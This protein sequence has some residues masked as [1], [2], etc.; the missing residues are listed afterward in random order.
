[1]WLS[2]TIG[3]LTGR[4]KK[5]RAAAAAISAP[6]AWRFLHDPDLTTSLEVLRDLARP[7]FGGSRPVA[8]AL[9]RLVVEVESPRDEDVDIGRVTALTASKGRYIGNLRRLLPTISDPGPRVAAL[10]LD[11]QYAMVHSDV[12]RESGCVSKGRFR[13]IEEGWSG[14]LIAPNSGAARRFA[15]LHRNRYLRP[16]ILPARIETRMLDASALGVLT[17]EF[18]LEIIPSEAARGLLGSMRNLDVGELELVRELWSP[19]CPDDVNRD[20]WSVLAYPRAGRYY[21]DIRLGLA[22]AAAPVFDFSRWLMMIA[23]GRETP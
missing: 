16:T 23:A 12:M 8:D 13:L 11:E 20:M 18:Q 1:M 7:H 17:R 19:A 9:E 10:S 14:R 22:D 2:G 6:K 15:W 4:G 3:R 5:V 21:E